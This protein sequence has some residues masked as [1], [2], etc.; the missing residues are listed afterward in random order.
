MSAKQWP[1]RKASGD[2]QQHSWGSSSHTNT[3]G[4]QSHKSG[5]QH[6]HEHAQNTGEQGSFRISDAG[7]VWLCYTLY[8]IAIFTG[9]L[10]AI[11]AVIINYIT[12]NDS[13]ESSPLLINHMQWQISTFWRCIV[14][15]LACA[16][17]SLVLTITVVGVVFIYPL[18]LG[19]GV[20][21]LYRVIRG[22]LALSKGLAVR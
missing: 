12:C 5:T 14:Y 2:G 21:Y 16:L 9:G 15:I 17:I 6:P 4:Q 22:A 11:V 13:K 18:W 1:R 7:L 8:G 19:L 3:N 20:W 10:A